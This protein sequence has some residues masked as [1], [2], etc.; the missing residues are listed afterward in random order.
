M[1]TIDTTAAAYPWRPDVQAFAPADVVPNALILQCANV[2]GTVQGDQPSV[3]VAY[4]DDAAATF[5][6][7]GDTI[8]D[9]P[10]DLSEVVVYTGKI[11]QLVKVTDEQ[12]GQEGTA[13]EL[14]TS[15]A[16]SIVYKADQAFIS[17]VAPV[18]PE[19]T[20][21][22]GLLNLS[23]IVNG[24]ELETDL[25]VLADLIAELQG[26]LSNPSA[27]VVDP[28]GWAE[29]RKLKLGTDF[30]ASLLGAGTDDAQ[31]RLLGI[32]VIVNRHVTAYSGLVI[33]RTA[34]AAAVGQVRIANSY[35]RYFDSDSVAVRA[36]WRIG[37][38][39]VRP[40]RIGRFTIASDEQG[41]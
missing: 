23:G 18:S 11:S 6:G 25:D 2:V 8:A 24:G 5:V 9:N 34:I 12:F 31:P 20:P 1:T 4:I 14:A 27:I 28:K 40:K 21:P 32:P 17:Q 33:D 13:R 29:L 41:S 39:L 26:N 22:A 30:S 7:E 35:D 19:V 37:W 16:R 15:V 3:R 36:T 38:N 10:P